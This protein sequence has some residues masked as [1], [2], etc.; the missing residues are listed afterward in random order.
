M[1]SFNVSSKTKLIPFLV[2]DKILCILSS[3]LTNPKDLSNNPRDLKAR[4]AREIVK[5]YHSEKESQKAEQEFE[6]IFRQGQLPTDIP[7]IKIDKEKIN[8]LDLL[9]EAKI[10]PSKSEA[11]RLVL[12]KGVRI[13]D[14]VQSDWQKT[15]DIKKGMVI[16]AGKR[17]FVKIV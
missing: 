7:E 14:E 11:K 12:Q 1:I 16:N 15:V 2:I 6:K 10:A 4:L 8:I 9:V 3:I 17:R 13:N 5:M